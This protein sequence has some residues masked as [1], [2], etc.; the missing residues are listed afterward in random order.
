MKRY[1]EITSAHR[2]RH[3]WPCPSEFVIPL[4]CS[5]KDTNKLSAEDPIVDGYPQYAWYQLPY[6]VS[7]WNTTYPEQ[8]PRNVNN[9]YYT[10]LW[11]IVPSW[12]QNI[13]FNPP[14]NVN[15]KT[16]WITAMKFSGGTVNKPI[17]NSII[18]G[19]QNIWNPNGNIV[20]N[21]YYTP[22]DNYFAGALILKF[23]EDPS[24]YLNSWNRSQTITISP[25]INLKIG[26]E[27]KQSNTIKG[28]ITC[29]KSKDTFIVT[30]QENMN[31]FDQGSNIEH[32][33]S[34]TI[35]SIIFIGIESDTF[36][37][38]GHVES[39]VIK[40]YN[41]QTGQ[42]E[43][44][45][46]FSQDTDIVNSYFLIDFNTDPGND[47]SE[48]VPGGPRI[49]IPNGANFAQSYENMNVQNYTL[50]NQ[51]SNLDYDSKIIGYDFVRKVAK[52]DKPLAITKNYGS[53]SFVLKH[54][55][56]LNSKNAEK[57]SLCN[58]S[59]LKL[60]IK[61]KGTGYTVG[62]TI[63]TMFNNYYSAP[64]VSF[65][66]TVPNYILNTKSGTG[67]RGIITAVDEKGG[68]LNIKTEQQGCGYKPQ[69]KISLTSLST[70]KNCLC[71]IPDVYQTIEV[72][73]NNTDDMLFAN[74]QGNYLFL[75]N[76]N[77]LNNSG[78]PRENAILMPRYKKFKNSLDIRASS[79]PV[80]TCNKKYNN[81]LF[82]I[83]NQF[84][85]TIT[86][87][88]WWSSN[89]ILQ[90]KINVLYLNSKINI[91]DTGITDIN[92]ATFIPN[93]NLPDNGFI[94]DQELEYLS[95]SSNN[96]NHLN[97]TGTRI[98]RSQPGCY[99]I[100]LISLT[101][102]NIPLDNKI[103]GLISFYPYIYIELRSYNQAAKGI[104]YSNNPHSNRALFRVAIRDTSTP[105]KS[106]FIKLR[107]GGAVQ[108]VNFTPND[109]LYFR[110]YLSNG[111]LF[112]TI[113][114]DTDSPLK[115][116]FFVQ[117]SAQ[118]EFIAVR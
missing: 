32:T 68:I 58:G 8:K 112:K 19:P 69:K 60:T 37:Y 72:A 91:K 33:P 84:T 81:N 15:K 63:G 117:I 43:L 116:D 1:V 38:T 90:S 78:I 61:N 12:D 108:T 3:N 80:K 51:D 47:W 27:I 105:I 89:S 44:T 118:F 36:S 52:L 18:T 28:N 2:N 111:E 31:S 24:C 77:I 106:K 99:N 71:S 29:I 59:I 11:P 113:Q 41:S 40:S 42:I 54:N 57:L 20:L 73:R 88:N 13:S 67:F 55:S 94:Q 76:Y 48:F 21:S 86:F 50:S 7:K 115:P 53:D 109:N 49:F 23:N 10:S 9:T 100:K 107:G 110:V 64:N 62:E 75:P 30:L 87:G 92:T 14:L 102:P 93:L 83:V 34:G 104:L 22:I 97:F 82:Q 4:S 26:D 6:V 114:K 66:Y 85:K 74:L 56:S 96:F 16:G 79:Y 25:A 46:P 65:S 39:S 98:G 95:F 5:N 103:G 35:T 101:L 45:N 70:G 17:L